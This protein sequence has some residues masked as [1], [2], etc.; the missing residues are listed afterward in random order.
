M[1]RTSLA[2]FM[3]LLLFTSSTNGRKLL[4]NPDSG[5]KNEASPV[6]FMS[7]YLT[8]LPKG[9]VPA[10]APSKKGHA[11]TTDEKLITRH[12]ITVDRI[13]RSVPSPGVGH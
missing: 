3:L 1:A 9:T 12:L 2:L 6:E 5:S 13:L 11:S 8:S 10:S 7:L 4:N